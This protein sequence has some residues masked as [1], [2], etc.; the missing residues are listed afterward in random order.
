MM[1]F[2]I[3]V[4]IVILEIKR[5]LNFGKSYFVVGMVDFFKYG[6]IE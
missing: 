5:L 2:F 3:I 1:Y 4:N 6:L